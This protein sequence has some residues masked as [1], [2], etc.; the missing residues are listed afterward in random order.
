MK[1]ARLVLLAAL[2][3]SPTSAQAQVHIAWNNCITEANAADNVAY[4]CDGSRNGQPFR[5]VVSVIPPFT[6]TQFVGVQTLIDIYNGSGPSEHPVGT[7]PDFWRLDTGECRDGNLTAPEAVGGIGSSACQNP[8]TVAQQT[9]TSVHFTTFPDHTRLTVVFVMDTAA[10]LVTGQEYFMNVVDL[11]TNRDIYTG[12]GGE[13]AGC[14]SAVALVVAQSTLFQVANTP[15]QDT[16][17]MSASGGQ[18]F[19]TW[20]STDNHVPGCAATPAHRSTWGAIKS[21][22]R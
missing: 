9:A 20:Q 13:C 2:A 5:F 6:L 21:T 18:N 15:P 16:V 3:L 14:C 8:W 17:T 1:P 12:N 7:L 11:D 19:V 10:Q 22:Y 4:A